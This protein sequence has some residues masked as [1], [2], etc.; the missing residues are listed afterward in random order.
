MNR[1]F[2]S[3]FRWGLFF[4]GL[5][6]IGLIY[7]LFAA[8][9]ELPPERTYMWISFFIEYAVFFLPITLYGITLKD[10][11]KNMPAIIMITR[12][13]ATYSLIFGS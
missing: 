7:F 2:F 9:K 1:T 13:T 12:G 11:D 4:L 8:G 3:I 6:I 5:G 10:F